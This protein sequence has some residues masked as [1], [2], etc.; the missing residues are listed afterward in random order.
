MAAYAILEGRYSPENLT[1]VPSVN[2]VLGMMQQEDFVVTVFRNGDGKLQVSG[3]LDG[4][5][6]NVLDVR[7]ACNGYMYKLDRM[8]LPSKNS[9]EI[10]LQYN[11]TIARETY[12]KNNLSCPVPLPEV[13]SGIPNTGQWSQVLSSSGLMTALK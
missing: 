2:S 7:A 12:L 6:A 5:V 13:I 1:A 9:R 11:Q 3:I 10:I 8:L 4:D